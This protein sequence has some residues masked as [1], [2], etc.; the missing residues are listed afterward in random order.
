MSCVIASSFFSS[1]TLQ[2]R[3]GY[4]VMDVLNKLSNHSGNEEDIF[5]AINL[6]SKVMKI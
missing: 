3:S 6:M 1:Q 4:T 5:W 2:T